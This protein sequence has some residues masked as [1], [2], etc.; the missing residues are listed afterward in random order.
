MSRSSI[1][2]NINITHFSAAWRCKRD[3]TFKTDDLIL[4]Y[5]DAVADE[6]LLL[7]GRMKRKEE[8]EEGRKNKFN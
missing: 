3:R 6:L 8:E 1:G 5:R 2:T 7:P 4:S